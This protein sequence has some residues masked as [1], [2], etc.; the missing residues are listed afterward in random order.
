MAKSGSLATRLNRMKETGTIPGVSEPKKTD[1]RIL[2][3]PEWEPTGAYTFRRITRLPWRLP[4]RFDS[5]LCDEV[6]F[7]TSRL[8]FFDLETTGLSSGA[9]TLTFLFGAGRRRGDEL[10]ITQ[11]FLSDFPG[12]HEYLEQ[13]LALIGTNTMLVSYNGAA[14]D[15]PLLSTRCALS[16]L[17]TPR[18]EHID[19]LHHARRLWKRRI[20]ACRLSDI[21]TQ[22][23]GIRRCDDIPGEE[24]PDR[25]F[26]F[27]KTG[28]SD[29]LAAVCD[30][31]RQDIVS[32]HDLFAACERNYLDCGEAGIDFYR[33]GKWLVEGRR[34]VD[35]LDGGTRLL[36][37]GYAMGEEPAGLLLA[38]IHRRNGDIVRARRIW[39]DL[40]LC[41]NSRRGGIALA[42]HL[43]HRERRY[44]EALEIV[45]SILE[46]T[47]TALE[48]PEDDIGRRG[49]SRRRKRLIKRLES[50]AS[51]R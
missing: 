12:E 15:L 49:L 17:S 16:G 6:D 18:R 7:N 31:H 20:G 43:E 23:L 26:S 22:I 32:L 51:C 38:A 1:R 42:K 36:E 5:I 21:E 13:V 19:L 9:G 47:R 30:H 28:A 4:E 45:E 34:R 29:L 2:D 35:R 11:L 48:P 3:L 33:A 24:I 25:Y 44:T 37:R 39:S 41:R 27:L 10:E 50:G 46:D 8:C 14:F 40:Y